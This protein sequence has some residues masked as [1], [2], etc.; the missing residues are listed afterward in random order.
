M[1]LT[2]YDVYHQKVNRY[3]RIFPTEFHVLG[4]Y[5]YSKMLSECCRY[6]YR[7][8]H[9][10]L[11]NYLAFWYFGLGNNF[12][13]VIMLSAAVDIIRKHQH[14]Q[15]EFTTNISTYHIN[16]TGIG[17]GSVLLAD[18]LPSMIFKFISPLFIQK[19]HFQ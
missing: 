11:R 2:L 18:I 3:L 9:W 1:P 13:Y 10:K 17:T 12:S 5:I 8:N 7:C 19:L 16:C 6:R 15:I 14:S 4:Q